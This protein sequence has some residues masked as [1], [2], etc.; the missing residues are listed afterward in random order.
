MKMSNCT[1]NSK[2]RKDNA[3]REDVFNTLEQ[4]I[5]IHSKHFSS[6]SRQIVL[7]V[8]GSIWVTIYSTNNDKYRF[9]LF[10]V[11]GVGCLY[12][13]I[14]L[15]YYFTMER[16]SRKLHIGLENHK[17]TEDE[18]DKIWNFVSDSVSNILILRIALIIIMLVLF[19]IYLSITL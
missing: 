6:I 3:N 18:V 13:F 17:Y 10:V 16:I 2:P 5:D 19:A 14:E 4:Y 15:L 8:I 9:I 1:E 11:L 12:L 7:A